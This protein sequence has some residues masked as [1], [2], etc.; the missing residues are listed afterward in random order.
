MDAERKVLL[1]VGGTGSGKSTMINALFNYIVGVD[2]NDDFR[3][4]LVEDARVGRRQNQAFSQTNWI[5]AYTIHAQSYFRVNF[6]LTIVDT[7]GFC[8]TSGIK[9]DKEITDQMKEFFTACPDMGIHSLDAVGFVV[10]SSLPRLTV[11][12]IHSFES[13]LSLFAND[14]ADNIFMLLSFADGQKPQVLSGIHEAR[15]PYRNCFKFNNSALY[16]TTGDTSSSDIDDDDD[17]DDNFDEMFWR[18]TC[19]SLRTFMGEL[20]NTDAA[21]LSLT[22]DVFNERSQ[23]ENAVHK[24]QR[25]IRKGLNKLEEIKSK[26]KR[27]QIIKSDFRKNKNYTYRVKEETTETE[28]TRPGQY[29]SNCTRCKTTCCDDCPYNDDDDKKRCCVMINGRCTVCPQ[30]CVWW[31]HENQPYVYVVSTECVWKTSYKMKRKFKEAESKRQM[32][33]QELDGYQNE[34]RKIKMSTRRLTRNARDSFRNLEEM[35]LWP[36]LT[37]ES[38]YI[39]LLIHNEQGS[40]DAGRQRRITELTELRKQTQLLDELLEDDFDP[41][42]NYF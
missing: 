3:L 19:S 40:F 6:T 24:L 37:N 15:L 25:K 29:T 30:R 9:R 36:K 16:A 41:F 26:E 21:T 8:D 35:A 23:L 1:V 34:F 20:C 5:T 18:M 22:R 31:R 10:Q 17:E 42:A 2:W 7:P 38:G 27:L 28:R 13:V 14:L 11:H 4:K 12:Q 39:D 33:Q 32:V